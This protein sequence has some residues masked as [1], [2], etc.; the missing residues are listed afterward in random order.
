VSSSVVADTAGASPN[1]G[2][3]QVPDGCL[4]WINAL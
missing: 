4:T 2:I 3:M 1:R